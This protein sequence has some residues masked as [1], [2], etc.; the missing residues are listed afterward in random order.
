MYVFYV[1]N[2]PKRK[3]LKLTYPR[4]E[5]VKIK[6]THPRSV[7]VKIKL[8]YPRSV[9]IKIQTVLRKLVPCGVCYSY[10]P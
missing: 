6:L 3:L 9:N 1:C 5:N 10:V 4:S 2:N 8:T 7:N